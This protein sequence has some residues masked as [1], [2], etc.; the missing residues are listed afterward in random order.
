[1]IDRFI[2]IL[3][4]NNTFLILTHKNPDGDALGSSLAMKKTLELIG[5]DVDLY[6]QTPIPVNL[7]DMISEQEVSNLD[8]LK[9]NYDVCLAMDSSSED[10]LFG[11]DLRNL[12]NKTI[13]IDHHITNSKFGDINV[14]S[15]KAAATG[16]LVFAISSKILGTLPLDIASLIYVAISTDTGH[17]SYSNTTPTTHIIGSKLLKLGVDQGK[18]NEMVRLKD[19]KSLIIRKKSLESIYAFNNNQILVM[20]LDDESI[21]ENTDTDGLID[22]IRYIKGCK[23]AALVK[24]ADENTFKVSLRSGGGNVN[25]AEIAKE[26]GGGGHVKAAGFTFEGDKNEIL[27]IL[28]DIDLE[29]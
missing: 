26:F 22:A 21:N 18:I 23:L 14:V 27:T 8:D 13:V 7:E 11:T 12:C 17:F 24:R 28:K 6:V 5:K 4:N 10:Y 15:E 16:E 2:E 9:A 1:M 29:V 20:V 19:L 3:E 25:A